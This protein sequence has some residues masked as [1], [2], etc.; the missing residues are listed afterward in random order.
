MTNFLRI[1]NGYARPYSE[2]SAV[3]IYTQAYVPGLTIT[4]GTAVTLPS[5]GTYT[6][7]EL[8]IFVNGVKSEYL[9]DF[10]YVGSGTKTQVSFTFDLKSS[11]NIEFIKMRNE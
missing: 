7:K 1:S 9:I 4:A 10:N 11:D 3:P 6:G 2:S 8:M 5:S